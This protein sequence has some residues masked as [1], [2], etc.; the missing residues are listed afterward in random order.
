MG[1]IDQRFLRGDTPSGQSPKRADKKGAFQHVDGPRIAPDQEAYK[2]GPQ[3]DIDGL[4]ALG[5]RDQPIE[6]YRVNA[7]A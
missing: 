4:I 2:Y 3:I 1:S 7:I 6:C 5:R